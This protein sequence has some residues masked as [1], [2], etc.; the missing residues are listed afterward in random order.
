MPVNSFENYPMSWKLDKRQLGSPL[1]LSIA[2][3]LEYDILNGYLAPNTKLPPQRELADYLDINLSTITRAFKIC[4]AKGLIYAVIGSGTFVSPN[5]GSAIFLAD[6]DANKNYI[7]MGVIKPLDCSN[8]L[9][10]ETIKSIANKNYLEKLLDYRHPLGCPYHRMAAKKW[11]QCFSMDVSI[12]NIAITSG[13]QNAI[14][15]LLISIFNPGDKIAVDTYTYP[16][17]IEL[18]NMLNIQ[19]IPI[20]ADKLGIIP[21]RLD[22]AC[23]INH[24]KGIYINPSCSNPTA[25]IMDMKRRKEIA[26]VIKKHKLILME[27]DIYSFLAPQG[28]LP[29]SH[30]IPEQFIYILSISKALSSGMRVGFMGYANQFV[31][32]I[33]RGIYNINIKTSSLNAEIITEMINT[34]IADKIIR[35]KKE[36]AEERNELYKQYFE[37]TNPHENPLSFF[38]WLPLCQ[39]YQ[40]KQFEQDA[41][42]HGIRVYHSYRFLTG[43]DESAQFIRISLTSVTDSEELDKG[44]R[45][46]N[47]FLLQT[48]KS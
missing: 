8:I 32:K 3:L 48:K 11:M 10:A 15:L 43:K 30:F 36:I 31:E 23:S 47:D 37:I 6:N 27:D 39:K 28:Y 1:Y 5:A 9:V 29:I 26:D 20:E 33:T 18:A 45:M 25:V 34:G 41:L 17:F 40:G 46:L 42:K 4:E 12:E 14:T 2:S 16:N 24:I 22:L 44:L 7:E 38:R 35:Q 21:E 13:G 19:L